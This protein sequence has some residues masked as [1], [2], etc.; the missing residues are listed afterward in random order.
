MK[1]FETALVWAT[2]NGHIEIVKL[3]VEREGIDINVKDLYLFLSKFIS[4]IGYFNIIK[5]N[6]LNYLIQH[7]FW[8]LKITT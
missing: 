7:L 2:R 8:Q 4:I 3:L 1:L 5:G 6:Y